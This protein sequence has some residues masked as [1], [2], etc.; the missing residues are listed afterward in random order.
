MVYYKSVKTTIDATGL[1]KIIINVV[2]RHHG[3][4]RSI[5]NDW[6]SLFTSQ[7]SFPLHKLSTAFHPQTDGGTER[8][9]STIKPY[10]RAFVDCEQNNW[11]RLLP[12]AEFGENNAK[13]G[14][15]GHTFFELNRNNYPRIRFEDEIDPCSKSRS[16]SA[17]EKEPRELMSICQQNLLCAQ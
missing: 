8:Q 6:G 14:S 11:A 4:S 12:M 5:L 13:N 17:W 7:F 10:P 1:T 15:T 9:N 2:L 16:A 3:V